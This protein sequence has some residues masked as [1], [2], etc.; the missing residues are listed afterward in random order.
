MQQRRATA[1]QWTSANPTLAPGEIGFETDTS[2]FKIG[3]GVNAWDTL[4]YFATEG[5]FATETYVDTAVGN[6]VDSAPGVLDTLNE[7]ASAIGDDANFV[8]TINTSI[9]DGDTATLSSAQS[10]ADQAEADAITAAASDATTKADTAESNA[11]SYTDTA[12]ANLVDTAPATLDTL[13]ELAA[14]LG[15][16]PSFATTVTNSLAA[17]APLNQ[18]RSYKNANYTLAIGDSGDF[19]EVNGTRTITVPA[20]VFAE[21]ARVDIVN[22]GT[23]VITIS[24]GSG[25]TLRSKDGALTLDAQYKAATVLFRTATDAYVIGDLA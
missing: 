4:D 5:A 15:D 18:T 21:G 1:A 11:N 16:D 25:M 22:Y 12:I 13:N 23:G 19:V 24:A 3:N 14:A 20:N 9:T 2:K 7:L 8:T 10:Y 17:K 6:L